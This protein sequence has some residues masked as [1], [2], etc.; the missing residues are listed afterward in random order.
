MCTISFHIS[1][2]KREHIGCML[3][4][5]PVAIEYK[6]PVIGTYPVIT[7]IIKTEKII[8]GSIFFLL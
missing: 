2:T 5:R 8:D 4:N 6:T 1:I 3:L 7:I